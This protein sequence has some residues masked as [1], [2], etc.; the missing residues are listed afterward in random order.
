MEGL[1][2]LGEHAQ[3]AGIPVAVEPL[4]R[5]ETYFINSQ[6]DT[7]ALMDEVGIDCMGLMYD[8]FH[9]N[10]EEKDHAGSIRDG[11]RHLKHVHIS[12][13][14][15]A[16]PGEDHIDYGAVKNVLAEVGYDGWLTLEAFG[17]ALPELAG[18]TCI[19][20]AMAPNDDYIAEQGIKFIRETFLD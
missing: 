14:D 17:H 15:R 20:R 6:A 9:A 8:T 16:T 5:F 7:A 18:A 11:A 2:A 19:W 13:N 10:I 3:Q 1:R 12:A 4:N